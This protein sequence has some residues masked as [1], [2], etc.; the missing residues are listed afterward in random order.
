MVTGD[1]SDLD[2]FEYGGKSILPEKD[3]YSLSLQGGV[4]S[5][6][7][8]AGL[9]KQLLQFMNAPFNVSV[10][11]V[12]LD[13]SKILY[14]EAFLNKNRG[15]K[16]VADLLIGN[17]EIEPFVVQYIGRPSI[18][19]TGFNGSVSLTLQVEP[20]I[21]RCFNNW[22]LENFKCVSGADWCEIFNNTE[23]GVEIWP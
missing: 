20:A 8:T 10:S 6:S 19:K 1:V 18:N 7:L 16:F 3:S 23:E 17:T 14:I 15:Q 9:D 4:E 5:S 12:G 11:Y 2:V 13:A 21:D 22:V